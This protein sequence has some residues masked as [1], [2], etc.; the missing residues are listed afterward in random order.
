MSIR[1]KMRLQ[2]IVTNQHTPTYATKSAK[3]SAVYDSTL[4]EDQKFQKATPFANAEF[5]ID[6]PP[7]IDQLV[8]GQD[9]YFDIS[10]VPVP[11]K[12]TAT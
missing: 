3:F 6:N 2:S 10:P 11:E 8:P 1:A 4:P 5:Q 7:A 9:Y 12:P